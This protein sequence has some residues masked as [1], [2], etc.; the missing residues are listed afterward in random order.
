MKQ[1]T[2]KGDQSVQIEKP[3]Y[4]TVEEA[5]ENADSRRCIHGVPKNVFCGKCESWAAEWPWILDVSLAAMFKPAI[6]P[7]I[8]LTRTGRASRWRFGDGN[9]E[10]RQERPSALAV[11]KHW[12][13][14]KLAASVVQT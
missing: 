2:N 10:S 12:N 11:Y 5:G 4:W 8:N 14:W 1:V 9:G 7:F 13:S 6:L 3:N